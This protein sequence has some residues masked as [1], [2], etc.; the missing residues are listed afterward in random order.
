MTSLVLEI[1][2]WPI[3]PAQPAIISREA[4]YFLLMTGSKVDVELYY[5]GQIIG[6]GKGIEGGDGIGPLS[7]QYD[8]IILRSAQSQTVKVAVTSDPVTITRL[9]GVVSV[10]GVIETAPDYSRTKA[11][12]SFIGTIAAGATPGEYGFAQIWNASDSG[13][14]I[15]VP[16]LY[17][18]TDGNSFFLYPTNVQ[19][20]AVNLNNHA[21]V[22]AQKLLVKP[23]REFSNDDLMIRGN[24]AN[25]GALAPAI[26]GNQPTN[27]GQLSNTELQLSLPIVLSPGTGLAVGTVL[28]GDG[29]AMTAVYFEEDV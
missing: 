1:D 8:K 17:V 22:S 13:K 28:V 11:G 5:K 21:A 9:S 16:D 26:V 25:T 14:N 19:G 4:T 10:N 2:D 7:H 27:A 3:T 29:I 6:Q 12:E 24:S 23:V 15:I 18:R 20:T